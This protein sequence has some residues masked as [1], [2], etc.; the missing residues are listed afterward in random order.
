MLMIA[1]SSTTAGEKNKTSQ[2][3]MEIIYES[4]GIEKKND[5][6]FLVENKDIEVEPDIKSIDLNGDGIDE[7]FVMLNNYSGA[8]GNAEGN[9]ILL[10]KDKDKKFNKNID[11]PVSA[12][13]ILKNKFK[14][15]PDIDLT[16]P[17]YCSS[18][19]RWDGEKYNFFKNK[20]V[21]GYRK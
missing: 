9:L 2:S 4:L 18:V 10:I 1:V 8:Y 13:S 15:Y 11:Y 12:Y 6:F 3:E 20:C 5:K 19:W 14:G 21:Q 16:I 7:V 17:G